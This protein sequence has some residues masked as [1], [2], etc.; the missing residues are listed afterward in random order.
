MLQFQLIGM[1]GLLSELVIPRPSLRNI[2][3]HPNSSDQG[4]HKGGGRRY[5]PE[6]A[7]ERSYSTPARRVYKNSGTRLSLSIASDSESLDRSVPNTVAKQQCLLLRNRSSFICV[8]RQQRLNNHPS[9]A[10]KGGSVT[11][12]ALLDAFYTKT[13]GAL[14]HFNRGEGSWVWDTD[15]NKFL[16]MTSG[17]GV[18]STGHCHPTVVEAVQKQAATIVHAQQNVFGAHEPVL[19]LVERLSRIVPSHLSRFFFCNSGAEAV[20]NAIKVARAH[21]GKQNIIAFEN[22]QAPGKLNQGRWDTHW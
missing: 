18:T 7:L 19:A 11:A 12:K 3:V 8:L 16:D 13:P 2:A 21:T 10:A 5:R 15:G 1:G 4:Y 6:A 17:I 14:S 22:P 9:M 20:D